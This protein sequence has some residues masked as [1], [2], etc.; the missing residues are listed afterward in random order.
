VIPA[1]VTAGDRGAAKPIQ[2]KS[3]VYLEIGGRPLVAHVVATLQR[4][5]E[6]S[7]VWVVGDP[8]RLVDALE[9]LVDELRKPLHVVPQFRNLYENC[10]ETYRRLLPGAGPQGRDPETPADLDQR[11]LYL[12]ADVPFMTPHEV[13][14]FLRRGLEQDLDFFCGLSSESSM[15]PFY[16]AAKG[17]PGIRMA[18][19][20]VREGRFRQ[21]NLH[22]V[23]P[24]RLEHRY[25]I[26]EMYE[27]RYQKQFWAILGLAW[28][29]LRSQ[30]GGL[31]TL[32]Y[33][34]LLQLT[35]FADRAGLRR[36]ADLLRGFAP[37]ERIERGLTHL[38]GCSYRFAPTEFGGAAVDIDN[39]ADYEAARARFEEWIKRELALGEAR[40]G[41]LLLPERAAPVE[42][43]VLP[44]E[45][46]S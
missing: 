34:L 46:S 4:V 28:R 2:G 33:Y 43:D 29:L 31:R 7:E 1:I 19:F 16:P 10:W 15:Q 37:I 42:I 14:H 20:N 30:S 24:G 23:R 18:Y 26:Q 32:C 13:S 25:Y 41:A 12:S 45:S 27:H 36:V 5:P 35:S 38:L 17:E 39:E 22:L 40:M 21:N 9:G 44:D 3:K 6:I 11:V 8:A